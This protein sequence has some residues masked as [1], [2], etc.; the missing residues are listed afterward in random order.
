MAI[1]ATLCYI[2]NKTKTLMLHRIKKK[3]DIHQGKWNGLG[4]KLEAGETPED[5]VV[6]EV[7]EESGLKI[8]DPDLRAILTFPKF[9]GQNDW[10]V[11]LFVAKKFLGDLME[12]SEGKLKWITT[13]GLTQLSL[14]EGDRLFLKWLERKK[15]FSA[16]FIYEKGKLK[17]Y[18]VHFYPVDF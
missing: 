3:N 11:F 4:G 5:C 2:Q 14:W 12:C 6:R 9:D 1:C 16:K 15:F 10:I 13:S 18:H 7:F 17:N 8:K